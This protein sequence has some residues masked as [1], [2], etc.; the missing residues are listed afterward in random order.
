MNPETNAGAL[1]APPLPS[2]LDEVEVE[3]LRSSG[4]GGQN[5]NKVATA[6]HLVHTPTGVE[7]R[8][9]ETKSQQQNRERARRLLIARV[10]E[11]ERQRRD[12]ERAAERQGQ[13]GRGDRSEKIRTYRYQDGI[14]ADQRLDEKLQLR[15]ILAGELEPMMRA[16]LEQE[17]ARRLAE[18]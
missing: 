6:V 11:I 14:V 4:P 9:Q 16:L 2:P 12:A 13:I 15:P 3:F 18:L 17:T 5:V 7:V 1:D 8:M 10:Y